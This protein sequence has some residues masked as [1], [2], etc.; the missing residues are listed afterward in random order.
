MLIFVWA[1]AQWTTR[2]KW[3]ATAIVILLALLPIIL[4]L[5]VQAGPLLTSG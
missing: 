2:Q 1:S 3:I 4:V 5:G